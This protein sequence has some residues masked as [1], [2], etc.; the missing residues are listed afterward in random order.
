[1]E[2]FYRV[3]EEALP[4]LG[5]FARSLEGGTRAWEEGRKEFFGFPR[6]EEEDAP[7]EGRFLEWFCLEKGREREP[8]FL[9][10]FFRAGMP[11]LPGGRPQWLEGALG[12]SLFGFFRVQDR[13]EGRTLVLRFP[14]GRTFRLYWPLRSRQVP[15]RGDTLL[16]RVYPF[17]AT[18]EKDL[19]LPS[20]WMIL[21]QGGDLIQALERDV[22]RARAMGMRDHLGQKELEAILEGRFFQGPREEE[23]P[24]PLGPELP[25]ADLVD[26]IQLL[27]D[28]FGFAGVTAA[29]VAREAREASSFSEAFGEFLD[30]LAFETDVDLEE[31]RRLFL[32]LWARLKEPEKGGE[33][34]TGEGKPSPG[35]DTVAARPWTDP[36]GPCPCGSG[37]PYEACHMGRDLVARL[38][39]A[40]SK[41][42]K[43]GPVVESLGRALGGL[44]DDRG[45]DPFTA[46]EEGLT[47]ARA[48]VQEFLW[49]KGFDPKGRE[50]RALEEFLAHL[51]ER[52]RLL[53]PLRAEDL[54]GDPAR[55]WVLSRFLALGTDPEEQVRFLSGPARV[56][57]SFG[58]WLHAAHGLEEAGK[59]KEDLEKV[60]LPA[61]SRALEARKRLEEESAG[62]EGEGLEK[63]LLHV[64]REKEGGRLF[65]ARGFP[66]R[67]GSPPGEVL[68]TELELPSGLEAGDLV[69]G[70]LGPGNRLHPPFQVIPAVAV[71]FFQG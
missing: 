22:E 68:E 49:E 63:A 54:V 14:S 50:K 13:G 31:I 5:R 11:G 6:K 10:R 19:F 21:Y 57:V 38:E 17:R 12:E 1:M 35:K 8:S 61:F 56:L 46:R 45:E 28:K 25:L 48:L 58:T 40:E 26:R 39:E 34:R 27:F 20:P 71:P 44:G 60:Y 62:Q 7:R 36:E 43:L 55:E 2:R 33:E 41:E 18:G 4:A 70:A 52:A 37:L 67:E 51:E 30:Q 16:G 59:R 47:E 3:L 65:L 15:E 9:S 69:V 29:D 24:G 42:E 66:P 32:Q 64:V 53:P 23:G